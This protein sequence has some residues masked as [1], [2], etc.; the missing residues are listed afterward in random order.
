MRWRRNADEDIEQLR[1]AWLNSGAPSEY[2][3]YKRACERAGLQ[4]EGECSQCGGETYTACSTCGEELCDDCYLECEVCGEPIGNCHTIECDNCEHLTCEECSISCKDCTHNHKLCAD[5]NCNENQE[6][7]KRCDECLFFYCTQCADGCFDAHAEDCYYRRRNPDIT[8]RQL[9]RKVM[10]GDNS[11]V[12]SY[13]REYLRTHGQ[14]PETKWDQVWFYC[15]THQR[16]LQRRWQHTPNDCP[17]T[18]WTGENAYGGYAPLDLPC[19]IEVQLGDLRNWVNWIPE[20]NNLFAF[21]KNNFPEPTSREEFLSAFY[22]AHSHQPAW[23]MFSDQIRNYFEGFLGKATRMIAELRIVPM[24]PKW[25]L[26]A[27]SW[28]E[29]VEL[30]NL[31]VDLID[32]L[33]NF[34]ASYRF[35]RNL[36]FLNENASPWTILRLG[37]LSR[38]ETTGSAWL[39]YRTRNTQGIIIDT[40]IRNITS[41]TVAPIRYATFG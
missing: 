4:P 35:N 39:W 14:P 21:K 27:I 22:E 36:G 6:F 23:M 2:L 7:I 9:E 20:K 40:N 11:A 25:P 17:K 5:E 28:D 34:S 12:P 24:G 10:Q 18:I 1:R 13:I 37:G 19:D 31:R 32:A 16:P 29:V 8:L 15:N 33:P 38:G 3:P 30:T 41:E 26:V